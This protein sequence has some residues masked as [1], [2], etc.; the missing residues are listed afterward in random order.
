[1]GKNLLGDKIFGASV[2]PPCRSLPPGHQHM[3][4]RLWQTTNNITFTILMFCSVPF[5]GIKNIHP[6]V[7]PSPP[8]ISRT[9]L[10]FLNSHL[11]SL[12]TPFPS[13]PPT[14]PWHP[15][16]Y[17]LVS[18]NWTPRGTSCKCNHTVFVPLGLLPS[19]TTMSSRFPHVVGV[20]MPCLF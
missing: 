9:L 14:S 20:R 10:T 19:M 8:S 7:Q 6:V 13:P 15:L 12:N 16:S 17:F 11:S 1:L 3:P 2:V 5:R 4:F 18:M